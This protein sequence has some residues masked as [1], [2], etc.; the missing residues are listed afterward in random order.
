[1]NMKKFT[2]VVG[3]N[4]CNDHLDSIQKKTLGNKRKEKRNKDG[5]VRKEGQAVDNEV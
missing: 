4:A 5:I 2:L 3:F 1:M